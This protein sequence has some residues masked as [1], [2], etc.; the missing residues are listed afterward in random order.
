MQQTQSQTRRCPRYGCQEEE[1]TDPGG[2]GKSRERI[3]TADAR[4]PVEGEDQM[5]GGESLQLLDRQVGRVLM[6]RG[7]ESGFVQDH[8]DERSD[9]QVCGYGTRCGSFLWLAGVA[10]QSRVLLVW[11][12]SRASRHWLQS[13]YRRAESVHRACPQTFRK[14]RPYSTTVKTV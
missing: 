10:S 4:R 14:R 9:P 6:E 12:G 2:R 13:V 7:R 11:L 3:A 8:S 5:R 1:L